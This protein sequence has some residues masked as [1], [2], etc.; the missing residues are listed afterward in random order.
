MIYAKPQFNPGGSIT[1]GL[2]QGMMAGQQSRESDKRMDF[3]Q[4]Q[5]DRQ[6]DEYEKGQFNERM[7]N[8][9]EVQKNG[10]NI[11]SH[12]TGMNDWTSK[13]KNY[14]DEPRFSV[15][16]WA[17]HSDGEAGYTN[18]AVNQYRSDTGK[19]FIA[20][21]TDSKSPMMLGDKFFDFDTFEAGAS[22]FQTYAKDRD[23]LNLLNQAKIAKAA[24]GG[25]KYDKTQAMKDKIAIEKVPVADRTT[26]QNMELSVADQTL[27]MVK[28]E[29][30]D[31]LSS[32]DFKS[33]FNPINKGDF[34]S[35]KDISPSMITR[36]EKAQLQGG[37]KYD[38]YDETSKEL[39]TM[40]LLYDLS[41]KFTDINADDYDSGIVNK[42]VRDY[43]T[44][45]DK[46]GWEN[47]N[48]EDR[49]KM[50][51]TISKGSEVGMATAQ[52]L[53]D[54][55]GAAV[56]DEEFQRIMKVLTGGDVDLKNPQAV[57]AALRGAGDTMSNRSKSSIQGIRELYSPAD[58]LKLT[59]LY[60]QYWRPAREQKM[61]GGGTKSPKEVAVDVAAKELSTGAD[62]GTEVVKKVLFS[63]GD[64]TS[65]TDFNIDLRG[66]ERA[67]AYKT[68]LD[69]LDAL[70]SKEKLLAYAKKYKPSLSS[71]EW[72]EF[73]KRFVE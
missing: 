4:T 46:K 21:K 26:E 14:K 25:S 8:I 71:K 67:E 42:M 58:K 20:G 34:G 59:G 24:G 54:L 47:I 15:G 10:G 53:K 62:L 23:Q 11:G 56:S 2:L 7:Y 41:D 1:S 70:D 52:I 55:S 3:L 45:A 63:R 16:N 61:Q 36:A 50:L 33:I 5:Q 22:N 44:M 51:N 19:D 38:K 73:K 6:T 43:A 31:D 37:E 30:I 48:Q 72:A 13:S 28:N 12:L 66:D 64:K 49:T 32:P 39:N 40:N 18:K 27:G 17:N 35:V 68:S 9:R 29:A 65:S 57:A 69:N 60:N